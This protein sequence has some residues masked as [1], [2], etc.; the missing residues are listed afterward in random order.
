MHWH[1][2]AGSKVELA[3]ATLQMARDIIVIRAC[4]TLGIWSDRAPVAP[5]PQVNPSDTSGDDATAAAAS[6]LHWIAGGAD[7]RRR[8]FAASRGQGGATSGD[9]PDAAHTTVEQR[10][11]AR[12]GDDAA[13]PGDVAGEPWDGPALLGRGAAPRGRKGA[14]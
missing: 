2:V 4:Y 3:G 1:E 12:G 10:D 5:Q 9:A 14:A 7:D 6:Q 11:S 13:K 8:R